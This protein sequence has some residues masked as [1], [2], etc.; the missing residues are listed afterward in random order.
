MTPP[1][2]SD[3][4]FEQA[5]AELQSIV[6]ELES[7]DGS[8]DESLARYERGMILAQRCNDLLDKAELRVRELRPTGEEVDFSGPLNSRA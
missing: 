8:L 7:G 6:Q 1:S 3:L 2:I 5:L 4:T